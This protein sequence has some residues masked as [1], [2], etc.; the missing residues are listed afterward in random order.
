MAAR[1]KPSRTYVPGSHTVQIIHPQRRGH[2]HDSQGSITL[3]IHTPPKFIA[4]K[5][6]RLKRQRRKS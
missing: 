3:V 2:S 1:A 5:P 6:T 4:T